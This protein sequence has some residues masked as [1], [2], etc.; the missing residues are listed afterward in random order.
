MKILALGIGKIGSALLRDLAESRDV[1]EIVAGD[2]ALE[3]VQQYVSKMGWDNRVRAER[4]DVTD[5]EKLVRLMKDDVDAVASALISEY[6]VRVAEA[7]IEAGVGMVDVGGTPSEIFELNR[8]AKEAG[9]AIIPS[10]GLDPGIDRIMEGYAAKKLDKVDEIFLW[11]GGFPQKNTPG[12]NNPLRYKIAWHWRGAVQTNIGKA[13]ILRDGKVVD[14][15]KLTGPGNP[16]TVIFPDPVGECEAFFT[17]APFDTIEHLDLKEV[18]NAWNKTVRWKG[19]CD[20]WAK[21]IELGLTST[22]PLKFSKCEASPLDFFV[23]L[24]NR[25]LQYEEGEGDVVVERVQVGGIKNGKKTRFVYELVDF[26]DKKR[27]VSAMGRTTSYP[28]SILSQMI[29]RGEIQE[30]GVIHASKIGYNTETAKRFLDEMS[31]R[32]L[33]ITEAVTEPLS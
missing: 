14:V 31:E 15:E 27:Q 11:C 22:E 30:R 6:N 28:C 2:L 19:H 20:I 7:A 12:Y 26:Y 3:R 18:K 21:L 1:S 29:G 33:H 4:V 13:R 32:G 10:C 8:R 16:E 9:V 5:H 23:E 25:T 17:S 24:G